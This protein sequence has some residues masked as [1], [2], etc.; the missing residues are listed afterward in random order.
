MVKNEQGLRIAKLY[1]VSVD[2]GS[3]K[4]SNKFYFMEEQSDGTTKCLWGRVGE[5]G[6]ITILKPG[7]FDSVY[8]EK[9]GPRKNYTDQTELLVETEVISSTPAASGPV[10]QTAIKNSFIKR[11]FDELMGYAN[12][13]IQTNYKVSQEAVT[14]AQVNAA[15]ALVDE[16]SSEIKLNANIKS[17]NDKLLRL[18]SIIPRKMRDVHYH[19]ISSVS[20]KRALETAQKLIESEQSTLDTMAGQVKLIKQQREAAKAS[21]GVVTKEPEE[22]DMLTTMG[23]KVSQADQ[24]DIDLVKKMMGPNANQVRNVYCVIN[25]KTQKVYDSQVKSA[26]N[27][28]TELFWHGSRNE[29]WFNI[30][31]TGLL[32]RPSCAAHCGSM[33]GDGIYGANK[34]QKSIGYTSLRGSYWSNGSDSKAYLALFDFHVGN[35]K[36]ITHHNSDCYTINKSK[37]AK[38]GYDSVYAHGGADLRNDEFIVYDANQVTIKYLIEIQ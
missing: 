2:N 17:I 4:Q 10:K 36:D 30:I 24:K 14:E 34:A 22:V 18:Y 9:I 28:K 20:D 1:H 21:D 29:N 38:E 26:S 3:T 23:L 35:Q 25:T 19:L 32:I 27:K 13:S 12:K 15:Q 8:K 33:F 7:E 37:L 31:Q 11:L 6:K 16:I 5:T